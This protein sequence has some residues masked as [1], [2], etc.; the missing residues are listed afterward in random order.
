MSQMGPAKGLEQLKLKKSL[1]LLTLKMVTQFVFFCGRGVSLPVIW[2]PHTAM[3]QMTR[4]SY[5]IYIYR[6]CVRCSAQGHHHPPSNSL[7]PWDVC[8]KSITVCLA[9]THGTFW[10]RNR[11][12]VCDNKLGGIHQRSGNLSIEKKRVNFRWRMKDIL[13]EQ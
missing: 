4:D 11:A 10:V 6:I 13:G 12:K 5:V 7:C 9:F 8:A 2:G 1:V 3:W